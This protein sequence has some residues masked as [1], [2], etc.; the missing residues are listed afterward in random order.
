M[1]SG[2]QTTHLF[3]VLTYIYAPFHCSFAKHG[4]RELAVF[5]FI[6]FLRTRCVFARASLTSYRAYG[7]MRKR[8][9]VPF[10]IRSASEKEDIS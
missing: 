8:C 4:K 1:Y 9:G 7:I 3:T 10:I 5:T 6:G 2:E